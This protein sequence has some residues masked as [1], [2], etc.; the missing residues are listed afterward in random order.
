MYPVGI[1]L[2]ETLRQ[3]H[4]G[5]ALNEN[6]ELCE[7]KTVSNAQSRRR[8][9]AVDHYIRNATKK[10]EG[11]PVLRQVEVYNATSSQEG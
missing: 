5:A 4:A 9:I 10:E 2:T 7:M 6:T 3:L 1:R 11:N 8:L